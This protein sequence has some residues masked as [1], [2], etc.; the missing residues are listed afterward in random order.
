MKK[1]NNEISGNFWTK[2][3][4]YDAIVCTT[5]NVIK[6]NNELVMGAGIA[7]EFAIRYPFLPVQWGKRITNNQDYYV[8][9]TLLSRPHLIALQTK[10]NWKDPSPIS[11][12]SD[13]LE[14]LN[15]IAIVL[16]WN[17]ILMTKPGCGNGGLDWNEIKQIFIDNE[18]NSFYVNI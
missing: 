14:I 10:R 4:E 2:I 11:L 9:I 1:W 7:K 16:N 5:N 15:S 18:Y 17:K 8:L 12:V 3:N 13:S 6:N